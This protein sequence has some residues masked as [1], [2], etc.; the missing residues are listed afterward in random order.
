MNYIVD[1]WKSASIQATTNKS[2]LG[3]VTVHTQHPNIFLYAVP[4]SHHS[5]I[6]GWSLIP[7]ED[8]LWQ[9]PLEGSIP[10]TPGWYIVSK[11]GI[12]STREISA[13]P[14]CL[15]VNLLNFTFLLFHGA[16]NRTTLLWTT[17][18]KIKISGYF[19]L[20]MYIMVNA[21][22]CITVC[23]VTN[24]QGTSSFPVCC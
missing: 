3:H 17:L 12:Y 20:L 11:R 8:R 1:A 7:L 15:I 2:L 21:I 13:M 24:T 4:P 16:S 19:S 18:V 6:H 10:P 9:T 14:S 22:L 23:Q 5:C